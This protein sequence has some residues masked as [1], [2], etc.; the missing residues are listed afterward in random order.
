MLCR[1]VPCCAVLRHGVPCSVAM[2][3]VP[4]RVVPCSVA[5]PNAASSPS[6]IRSPGSRLRLLQPP[7]C[8]VHLPG[9]GAEER[10][11]PLPCLAKH[12]RLLP[13][14]GLC[15]P[16]PLSSLLPSSWLL[17][18]SLPKH[19]KQVLHLAFAVVPV[20]SYILLA[21]DILVIGFLMSVAAL[22]WR[23]GQQA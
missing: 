21:I 9:P 15:A 1:A 17:S 5:M 10:L 7:C 6:F 4:R 8:R 18:D 12:T 13:A 23:A 16:S 19:F 14:A 22:P 3:A 20:V 11:H 2:H